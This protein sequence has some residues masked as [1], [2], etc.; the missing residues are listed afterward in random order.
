MHTDKIST[1]RRPLWQWAATAGVVGAA[2]FLAAAE[3][4]ALLIARDGSPILA[5]GS[6]IIDIVPQWAK[7]FAIETFG[8]NDKLFLLIGL[9]AAIAVAAAIAGVLEYARPP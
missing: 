2:A 6:F 9:G 8:S 1:T 4:V 7:E 5:V 3:L